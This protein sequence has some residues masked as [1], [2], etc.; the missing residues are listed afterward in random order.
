MATALATVESMTREELLAELAGYKAEKAKLERKKG[1]KVVVVGGRKLTLRVSEKGAVSVYGLGRWPV[2][3]YR[4]QFLALLG[5][6]TDIVDFIG[7]N[8]GELATKGEAS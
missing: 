4:E 6:A 7:E 5:I 8:E 1:Q 3:L 2:T